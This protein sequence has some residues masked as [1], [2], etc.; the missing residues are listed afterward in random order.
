MVKQNWKV[1]EEP[2]T[3]KCLK[4]GISGKVRNNLILRK[5]LKEEINEKVQEEPIKDR[6][7][8]D[9]KETEKYEISINSDWD[10][11]LWIRN[12][13]K[14]VDGMFSFYVSKEIDHKDDD[15]DPM[16]ILEC[17]WT[18]SHNAWDG[19]SSGV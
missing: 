2:D 8:D 19:K 6:D 5:S 11:K 9:E 12:M 3:E 10:E 1:P 15:P 4:E 18:Y 17:F 7:P 16:S 14:D 13:I